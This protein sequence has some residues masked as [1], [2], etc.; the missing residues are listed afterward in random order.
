[1]QVSNFIRNLP[2]AELHVHVEGT[3]EPELMF[4][5]AARNSFT[6]SFI[7]ERRRG[8]LLDELDAYLAAR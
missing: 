6:A 8:E 4:E 3:F 1:M 7:D 2:K 5:I